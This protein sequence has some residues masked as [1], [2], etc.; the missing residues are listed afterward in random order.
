ME[1]R[2]VINLQG[3]EFVTYEGLLNEAHQRG[4]K[5]IRTKLVQ[6]PAAENGHLAVVTAEVELEDGKVFGGIGDASSANVG[7]AIAKH[8]VRMA[9]TRAKARALRDAVNIGMTALEELGELEHAPARPA[10]APEAQVLAAAPA[11]LATP[12]QI[13]KVAAE[14]ARVGWSDQDGRDYLIQRFNKLS[15][16]EL[17]TAE[18]SL[19]I[20]HLVSLPDRKAA[21]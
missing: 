18:I 20:D 19:M 6:L 9:E 11:R 15:R 12:K 2:H 8:L 7:P 3:Q 16:S 14:M 4:L 13:N 17:S 10:S 5:A 1:R 21:V